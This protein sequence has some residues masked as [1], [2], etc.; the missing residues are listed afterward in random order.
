MQIH[1]RHLDRIAE[2]P[3]LRHQQS[4]LARDQQI[5][6]IQNPVDRKQPHEE[7]V[8]PQTLRHPIRRID[9]LPEPRRKQPHQ[10]HRPHAH[11]IHRMRML[12]RIVR[13]VPIDQQPAP[14]HREQ[15]RKVHPVHPSN[16][17]RMLPLQPYR[18]R[19]RSHRLLL[20]HD[21]RGNGLRGGSSDGIGWHLLRRRFLRCNWQNLRRNLHFGRLGYRLHR[22]G[23]RN[24]PATFR[25][26]LR[27]LWH[28]SSHPALS[29]TVSTLKYRPNR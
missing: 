9:R 13:I 7:E 12:V 8:I 16:R 25:R 21:H 4:P 2:R 22:L 6:H 24:R 15:H 3:P 18:R 28:L 19:C 23:R 5:R 1:Q 29:R 17:Q 20:R 14:D 26:P 27:I 10:R 11:P